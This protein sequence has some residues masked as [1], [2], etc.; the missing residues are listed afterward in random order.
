[1]PEKT[2]AIADIHGHAVKIL[3]NKTIEGPA[4]LSDDRYN[5]KVV[6]RQDA[7]PIDPIDGQM[8][9]DIPH[10]LENIGDDTP[11]IERIVGVGVS[12]GCNVDSGSINGKIKR[13]LN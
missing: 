2:R 4:F 11:R 12:S 6:R 9:A 5:I 8:V 1:M 10:L 13:A 3:L 7:Y